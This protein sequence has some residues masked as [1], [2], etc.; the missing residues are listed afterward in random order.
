MENR[1]IKSRCVFLN[2]GMILLCHNTQ[3]DYYFFPGGSSDNNET[4]EETLRREIS[5]EFET[6][7]S[8]I[9]L[10]T[11]LTNVGKH[12]DET[13]S[14]FSATFTDPS[15]Y[16]KAKVQIQD[17]DDMNAEWVS[18]DDVKQNRIKLFPEYDYTKLIEKI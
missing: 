14:M 10:L 4:A 17:M 11:T 8:N 9:K 2:E 15:I 16:N 13:I 6:E 12:S 3:H 1:K 7:I 18:L 5:E